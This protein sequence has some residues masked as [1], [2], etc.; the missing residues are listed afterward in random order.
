M[1]S[2]NDVFTYDGKEADVTWNDK[3]CIH[4]Q[5]CGR[6][7]GELF[8]GGRKPWCQPDLTTVDEVLAVVRRCP[9]GALTV[10]RKDGGAT[11]LAD[12]E[13]VAVVINNGPLV[14]RGDLEI[15][16]APENAPVTNRWRNV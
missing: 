13:N 11:E 16:G 1:S 14:V 3:L 15:D 9:T 4:I 10:E 12:L 2:D 6:A 8:V 5:E 7:K